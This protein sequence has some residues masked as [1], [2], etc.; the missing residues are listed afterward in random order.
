MT[1]TELFHFFYYA[2]RVLQALAAFAG[3][4]GLCDVAAGLDEIAAIAW[5]VVRQ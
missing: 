5:K 1:P 2:R 3:E 4:E